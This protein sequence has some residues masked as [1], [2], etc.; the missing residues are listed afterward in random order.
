[1]ISQQTVAD[2]FNAYCEIENSQKLLLDI[3][4]AK[5]KYGGA[6]P[7]EPWRGA[8]GFELG[9]PMSSSGHRVFQLGPKLA[10][11]VIRAHIADTEALLVN[12]NERARLELE[13]PALPVS[14]RE[15]KP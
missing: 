12:A 5:E 15:A 10:E 2:I 3:K 11:S 7:R 8:R 4:E 1:M 6:T 14:S 9:V 13:I